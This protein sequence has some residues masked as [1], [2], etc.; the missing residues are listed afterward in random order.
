MILPDNIKKLSKLS[1]E[2]AEECNITRGQRQAAYQ[3]YGQWVEAGR[4]AGGLAL[5]NMLQSHCDRLASHLFSPSELRFG[6]DYENHYGP[7]ELAQA[8]MAA[9]L[10][11]REWERNKIDLLFGH[12][13]RES[14]VY[15]LCIQKLL[16][17]RD[18][19]NIHVTSRLV[20]PWNFGV[21]NE[22]VNDL[23]DQE[24]MC[25]TT[26]LNRHQV[27]RRIASL[28]DAD[29][30]YR[31]IMGNSSKAEGVSVP[32]SFMH[33]VLSTAVLDVSL[34]NATTPMPGGIVQLSND[35]SYSTLGPSTAE[36]LVQMF[37]MTVWDDLRNDWTTI[38]LI[39]PDVLIA[40]R[41]KAVN[42]FAPE[43]LCY[44]VIQP[45]FEAGYFYGRSELVDLISLQGWL[46]THMDDIR[47]IMGQ[48][49]D[50][51][52]NFSGFDGLTEEIYGE[53]RSQGWING[54]QAA[55]VDDL[56]PTM[57]TNSIELIN[58]ILMLMDR[59]SG[60]ENIASGRGEP[61]VRTGMQTNQLMRFAT[62]RLRDRALLIER[63]CSELGHS[64]F[65]ALAAKEGKAYWTK[66]GDD[67]KN[68]FLL[69]AMPDDFR[70]TVSSHSSSPVFYEDHMQ[71]VYA[72]VKAGFVDGESAIEL[73]NL[74]DKD[75]LIARYRE[76]QEKQAAQ[77][78]MI[79]Q[80][81]LTNPEA[82]KILVPHTGHR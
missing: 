15:G 35:P 7:D 67:R 82:A 4:Q 29:K 71:E 27:W 23:D 70:V 32:T 11:S 52:L 64:T 50:K 48:Q 72:G 65:K 76:K 73:S 69:D 43:T 20:M 9:R 80:L 57:P 26:Y 61:G 3:Q 33:S 36:Q 79:E 51:L 13:V 31:R 75:K 55:K 8:D 14:L 45:N 37:E 28:P 2:L 24:A 58:V 6:G 78:K 12:G 10:I 41:F 1:V 25:E 17:R 40:P 38:Q 81:A 49:F 42:L 19:D 34:Q 39:E 54:P 44:G 22:G 68:D 77:V 21:S 60:F 18:G 66:P 47:R 74:P 46:T 59:A 62:P 5:G 63:Q 16:A 53:F 30:L 56:T